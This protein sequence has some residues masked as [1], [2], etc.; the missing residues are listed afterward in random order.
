MASEYLNDPFESCPVCGGAI[1]RR[2]WK[3]EGQTVETDERCLVANHYVHAW[4]YGRTE[5][6]VGE[7]EWV[8][9]HSTPE[10]EVSRI[11]AEIEAETQRRI[12]ERTAAIH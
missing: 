10:A 12:A 6:R 4:S 8:Y 9:S 7:R 11:E 5:V 1:K 3:G 2:S